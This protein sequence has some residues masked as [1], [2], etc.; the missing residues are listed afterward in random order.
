M[1]GKVA[2]AGFRKTTVCNEAG[3]MGG[4]GGGLG[5]GNRADANVLLKCRTCPR[6]LF[7]GIKE[8]MGTGTVEVLGCDFSVSTVL[9]LEACLV[10]LGV[11]RSQGLIRC[12]WRCSQFCGSEREFINPLTPV[13]FQT[14][15]S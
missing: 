8:G 10:G 5:Q 1:Q 15:E 4:I 14:S 9:L 6:S 11:K 13:K 7:L 12:C 3:E 2:E